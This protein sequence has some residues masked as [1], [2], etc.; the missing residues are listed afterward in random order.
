MLIPDHDGVHM[1]CVRVCVCVF[2][3]TYFLVLYSD[4]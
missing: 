4:V 2:C 3:L 1:M